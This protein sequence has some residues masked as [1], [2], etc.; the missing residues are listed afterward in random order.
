MKIPRM[1]LTAAAS[2]SGKTVIACGLMQAFQKGGCRVAGGKC[3]PDYIDPMFHREVL[4]VE[5]QNLDL[6]LTDKEKMLSLFTDH[7][8]DADLTIVEGVMGYYDGLSL[9]SDQ[10]S[11]YEMAQVLHMPV[12]LV[13]P[14]K[15]MALS[16]LAV[17]K[18]MIEF[19]K[20]SNI[21]G[22]ILNR[23]S[24]GLY[25]RMKEMIEAE[26]HE[27]GHE[28]P[29]VGYVPDDPAFVLSS[30]HL[31]LVL[32]EEIQEIK[33]QMIRAGEILS[34][35]VDLSK[36]R[37]IMEAASPF[38]PQLVSKSFQQEK[39]IRIGM[40]RDAAFGFYYKDNLKL[41]EELGCELIPFS[42]LYDTGLPEGIQG[43][44]LPGGYPENHASKLSENKAMRQAIRQAVESGIPCL[45]ECGGFLYLHEQ[46]E[47]TDGRQ[48]EMAGVIPGRAV[49]KDRLV[50]FGY[51]RVRSQRDGV[52]LK[53]GEEIRGHEF[54][55][56]DSTD[57]GAD[58]IAL[59][60]DG[61][62]S[63]PCIH[64]KGNLMAGYPHLYFASQ[65]LL[66]ERF[67][68]QSGEYGDTIMRKEAKSDD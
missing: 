29:V 57:S 44:L 26:L 11:S 4:G 64:M 46:L 48:Y 34:G 43:L 63:W 24:P 23:I 15:G 37:E 5:S 28:I 17:L 3:G 13:I 40:A 20:N 2:G 68:Y 33:E 10:A 21:K 7:A 42:P 31:G 65:P 50:R 14:A 60:P 18:G 38:K 61:R 19:R 12:I 30:R 39:R 55:Y 32:P 59:K 67:V 9:G 62:R 47:G 35:T 52:Y 45:A 25:P 6:F 58:C 22:L 51:V 16:I 8:K 54:H 53:S 36:I 66:A 27:M 56:W 49:R 41:L 1:M